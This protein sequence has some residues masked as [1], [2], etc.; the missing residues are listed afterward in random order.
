VQAVVLVSQAVGLLAVAEVALLA[1]P[2]GASGRALAAGALAGAVGVVSAP[3]FYGALARGPMS[4]VAPIVAPSAL[5]PAAVGLATGE[6]PGVP[7]LAGMAA[8][9][10]GVV[11]AAR[12]PGSGGRIPPATVVLALAATLFLGLQLV[13]LGEAAD[14][15]APLWGVVAARATSG[16]V[17]AAVALRRRPHIDRDGVRAVAPI[18]LLDTGANAS[19]AVAAAHGDLTTAAVLGSL[20]PVVTVL[21]A[22]VRLGERLAGWQGV[23]A[24]LA[25]GGALV[26]VG[27]TA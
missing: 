18:G 6:R 20:F 17:L 10:G 24:G 4:V 2:D 23:G 22:H 15:G 5:A 27:A 19:F 11:L 7:A 9:I 1:E 13:F 12:E 3:C 14:A 25:V 26:V 8:A 16:A 21:I